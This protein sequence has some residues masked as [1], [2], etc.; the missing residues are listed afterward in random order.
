MGKKGKTQVVRLSGVAEIDFQA[1]VQRGI[2]CVLFDI[3]GT[4]APWGTTQVSEQLK[5]HITESGIRK[6]GIVT[7]IH[8]THV[9]RA[10]GF[11]R[12]I[13]A[14]SVQVPLSFSD[15]KPSARM[16]Q[17]CLRDLD[18]KREQTVM[19]GDK[20]LDV[21]AAKNAGLAQAIWVDYLPG[22]DH[23]FDRYVYR[24]IEPLLKK[25]TVR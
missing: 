23:W 18:A 13:G 21:L 24:R 19:V 22:P 8:H 10:Q 7:N 11:G 16:I 20:L 17:A 4:I 5:R 1:L 15:R 9:D 2:T 25:I 6:I 3:E 12:Q 14:G